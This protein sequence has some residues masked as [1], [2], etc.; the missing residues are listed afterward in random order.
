MVIPKTL[1]KNYVTPK[2]EERIKVYK[3]KSQ[4]DSIVYKYIMGP[5]ANYCLKFTPISI[6]PNTLT[7]IG[8]LFNVVVHLLILFY[9]GEDLTRQVPRWLCLLTGLCHFIYMNFDNMDGKQARRTGSS[10][11]LGMLYDHGLDAA[12]GWMIG[13]N[14]AAVIGIGNGLLPFF[15]LIWVPLVGFYFTMWEEYHLDFLNFGAVNPVDEGLSFIN[16]CIMF[17]GVVGSEWWTQEGFFGLKRNY[18]MIA[19]VLV[20]ATVGIL[21]NIGR[22]I[23]KYKGNF[24]ETIDKMRVP[25]FLVACVFLIGYCSPT[26]IVE[27]RIRSLT[28]CFGLAFSKVIGHIQLAHCAGDE[29]YQ[30]RKSFIISSAILVSN[31]VLGVIRG[32]CPINEDLL[33]NISIVFNL[34]C[35]LHYFLSITQQLTRVLNIKVFSIKKVKE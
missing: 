14:L 5:I 18:F 11:S 23:A 12:S 30:W 19:F 35:F 6:A 17:T 26:N 29:F 28:T 16:L 3:Y 31:T 24:L 32:K 22:V 8:F 21:I 4:T 10:S 7:F 34:V 25:M 33:L 9:T 15:T 20:V 1:F 13:L 27:R 2:G